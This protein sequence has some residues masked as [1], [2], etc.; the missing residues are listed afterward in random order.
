MPS[1]HLQELKVLQGGNM[2]AKFHPLEPSRHSKSHLSSEK[3]GLRHVHTQGVVRRIWLDLQT[4]QAVLLPVVSTHKSEVLKVGCLDQQQ[5]HH[6]GKVDTGKTNCCQILQFFKR[7]RAMPASDLHDW[8]PAW[9]R[10]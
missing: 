3:V 10:A 1:L 8:A 7:S 4:P 2:K 9:I 5:H 6:L